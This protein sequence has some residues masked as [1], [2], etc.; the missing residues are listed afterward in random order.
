MPR[1]L[2]HRLRARTVLP[3]AKSKVS[4]G[5]SA[6]GFHPPQIAHASLVVSACTLAAYDALSCCDE[7]D[8]PSLLSNVSL[9]ALRSFLGE[10][11][12]YTLTKH[13]SSFVSVHYDLHRAT[14]TGQASGA[15][16][17]ITS[18][19][20]DTL[21][22]AA[23]DSVEDDLS[24]DDAV[25]KMVALGLDGELVVSEVI[26]RE[27]HAHIGLL[28]KEIGKMRAYTPDTDPADLMGY[29]WRGLRVALRQYDPALGYAFSTYACPKINGAIRDG[30]RSEHHLPKRLTTFARKV[31]AAQEQLT[32]SLSRPP[33]FA[34]IS[35]YLASS[36]SP[37]HLVP[38]LAA[39][40]SLEE[41]TAGS[42]FPDSLIDSSSPEQLALDSVRAQDI[43]DALD[44][45]TSTQRIIVTSLYFS[46]MSLASAAQAAGVDLKTA[47]LARDE[48]I[49]ALKLQL[50]SWQLA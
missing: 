41:L 38:R 47:R 2:A 8:L 40:A 24:I 12:S 49:E 23:S 29:A 42:F 43:Q 30:I 31:S 39:P 32:H 4:R 10:S 33:S 34:D 19:D 22:S 46:D 45:L 18:S 3:M 26:I 6:Q 25:A 28:H 15:W 35:A 37:V 27:T 20:L 36:S 11:N 9:P 13:L 21:L 5:R 1:V 50:F 16:R 48:A 44:G 7:F 17:A 14:S